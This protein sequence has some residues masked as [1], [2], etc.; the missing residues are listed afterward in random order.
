MITINAANVTPADIQGLPPQQGS[1]GWVPMLSSIRKAKKE[2]V[3][4]HFENFDQ[5][6]PLVKTL[7]EAF[8][9]SNKRPLCFPAL[10]PKSLV[11]FSDKN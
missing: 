9:D 5:A 8:N 3:H 7:I 11:T 2:P 10:H 4:V 1:L 6:L